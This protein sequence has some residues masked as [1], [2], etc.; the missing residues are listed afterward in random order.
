MGVFENI[1]DLI[2]KF[3]NQNGNP[4]FLQYY[5]VGD[6][7]EDCKSK[8]LRIYE[9]GTEPKLPAH[10]RCDCYYKNVP[11][12]AAGTVSELGDLAP[13][14]YLK[15]YGRL[16]DYYITK[17]VA[18][19]LYGWDNSKNLVSSKAPG[20]MIGGNLYKNKPPILPQKEKRLWYECDID[21]FEGKRGSGR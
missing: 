8:H 5:H 10:P 14:V 2:L 15:K 3:F 11:V 13:D 16:P 12:I 20:K 1:R 17:E 9:R 18:E 21:Y 19:Q 4:R 6:S 7:C